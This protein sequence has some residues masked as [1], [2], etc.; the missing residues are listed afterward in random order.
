VRKL[1]LL[2]MLT[3]IPPALSFCQ[4]QEETARQLYQ[5]Y[6]VSRAGGDFAR[7]EILLK[8][9][10][11]GGFQLPD[12]NRALVHSSL[13]FV[14]YETGNFDEALLQYRIAGSIANGQDPGSIDIRLGIHN[15]LAILYKSQGDYTGALDHYDKAI[16]LMDSTR[17]Q[18][19]LYFSRL[20]MLQ[21]NKGIVYYRLG[22][23]EEA[24]EILKKSQR[25]KEAYGYRYLGSVYFNLARVYQKLGEAD[26]AEHY[27]HRAIDRWTTEHDTGYY[28]L[29]N[30]YLDYGQFLAEQGK[31]D[32]G[33]RFLQKA[34]GNYLANYGARHPLTAACYEKM[35][36]YHLDRS[37]YR[38]G[39]EYTQAALIAVT[40]TFGDRNIF[41]NPSIVHSLHDLTLMGI[42]ATKAKAL[43]GLANA[44]ISGQSGMAGVPDKPR[45]RIL[46]LLRTG[47]EC[48]RLSIELLYRLQGSYPASESRIYLTTGQKALFST[49]IRLNLRLFELTGDEAYREA[50]FLAAVGG[51]SSELIYEMKEKE[52]LYLETLPDSLAGKILELKKQMDYFTHQVHLESQEMKP[53]P[54]KLARLEEQL[55]VAR[56][57]YQQHMD[58]LK[59]DHPQLGQFETIKTGLSMEQIRGRLGK[60]A[61]LVEYFL[62]DP[63]RSGSRTATIFAVTRS[64]CH[65]HQCN[66]DSSFYRDLEVVM[67][68]L[69]GFN[70]YA[71]SIPAAD[72]LKM[73]LFNLYRQLIQPVECAFKGR[74]LVIVPH[75]ELA[76]LPFDALISRYESGTGLNFTS[77]PYL[78]R[79]YNISYL[80][81]A[82]LIDREIH[83]GWR[84][85]PVVA[86]VPEY[87]GSGHGDLRS[88]VGAPEEM[89]EILKVTGGTGI[90]SNAGKADAKRILEQD[91]VLHL[92][93]HTLNTDPEG[94]FTAFMLEDDADSLPDCRLYDYEINALALS[95]PMV[96][97][98][99]CES[100]GGRLERGEGIMSLSRSFLLAGAG[101][102]VHTL[103]PLDDFKGSRLMVEFYRELKRGHSKSSALSRAKNTYLARTAPSYAHPYYWAAYQVIGNPSRLARNRNPVMMFGG[104]I[105]FSL[106]CY[107]LIRRS[108]LRRS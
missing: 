37:D 96:V 33:Y 13:G 104:L 7:A 64:N 11:E 15:D 90:R 6:R 36:L 23:W 54:A 4:E 18:E 29:A 1:F 107:F 27:Y 53:D 50:A 106:V 61:T 78:V 74:N 31:A 22:K 75:E 91:A 21:F 60:R 101:S 81:N 52:L 105:V 98:S 49:G 76:F 87:A 102:V 51:K 80:Y 97:L 72:S 108:F 44:G 83:P 39:L 99:S 94:F 73:A 85:P 40:D 28:E 17:M 95:A 2:V 86:W 3:C 19:D 14:Y 89:D 65:V 68:S 103:W 92:A 48:N 71:V 79:S 16:R 58:S 5:E 30:I 57:A 93:M 70:P 20:S 88:L 46:K 43:E 8:R 45:E 12:Y 41:S 38:Q 66:I 55:F 9:I 26:R 63:D 47:L 69:R 42:Y 67:S 25:I 34:L 24:L 62:S 84:F 35:A 77:W 10:L 100:G 56:L 32:R 82:Q 59:Q